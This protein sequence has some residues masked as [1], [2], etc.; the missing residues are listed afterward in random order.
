MAIFNLKTSVLL[1]R[2]R[3]NSKS[4]SPIALRKKVFEYNST[5]SNRKWII[6]KKKKLPP[7]FTALAVQK[8][9]FICLQSTKAVLNLVRSY[10]HV[11]D[12]V[13]R[14]MRQT[15]IRIRSSVVVA[16]GPWPVV[17][18]EVFSQ[19]FGKKR[20]DSLLYQI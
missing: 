10:E 17:F 9:N 12:R 3:K 8:L 20:G 7:K 2:G 15:R 16:H 4:E 6:P 5:F 18:L 19:S 13:K 1:L 14:Q 11:R